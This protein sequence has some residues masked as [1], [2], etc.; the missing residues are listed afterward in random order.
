MKNLF[1]LYAFGAVFLAGVMGAGVAHAQ[2]AK[3]A[4]D[5]NNV[6]IAPASITTCGDPDEWS[7]VLS[8]NLKTAN[9]S[10]LQLI[11]SAQIGLMTQTEVQSKGGTKD[12]SSAEATVKV[13]MLIDDTPSAPCPASGCPD[14][15][16]YPPAVTYNSRTQTL[17]ANL[18]GLNCTADLI[19]GVVTCDDPEI[20]NLI[21]DT[22]SAHSFA[23]VAPNL[24][25]GNHSVELQ[26]AACKASSKQNGS[27]DANVTMGPGT[28]TVEE[29]R[30]TNLPDGI[31]IQ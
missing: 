12:T 13:R 4:A 9:K 3:Y 25:S 26:I 14:G 31:T 21:L 11:G 10:D 19:T 22:T 5:I 27:A 1:S 2:S 16:A 30:A 18:A 24:S 28:L 8:T 17:S 7:T 15:V 6:S 20:I 29:V 23:F